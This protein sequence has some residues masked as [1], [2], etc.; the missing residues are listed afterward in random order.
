[1]AFAGA[2]FAISVSSKHYLSFSQV[3]F[4]LNRV[5]CRCIAMRYHLPIAHNDYEI[6]RNDSFDAF[7]RF[8]GLSQKFFLH[9]HNS[10]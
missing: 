8:E 6:T 5:S 7:E 4:I 1:M 9:D 3:F 2:R 10:N